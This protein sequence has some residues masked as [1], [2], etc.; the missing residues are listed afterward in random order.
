MY[1][2]R[3]DM[4]F[5][6]P[7]LLLLGIPLLQGSENRGI[8]MTIEFGSGGGSSQQTIY[9]QGDRKRTEY[10]N[11]YGQKKADGSQQPIYGPRIVSITRCDLGQMFELNLDASEYI[12]APYPPKPLTKEEV[13][14][15]GL[16]VPAT[17][18]SDRPTLRIEVTTRDTGERKE[19]FGHTARHVITTR[20]QTPLEGSQSEPQESVTDGWYIDSKD[21]DLNQRL[22]CDR[23]LPEGKHGHTYGYLLAAG[24]NRPVDKP[25]F[26][27]IGEPETGFALQSA[28]TSRG[29]YTPPGGSK[30]QSD[31]RFETQVTQFE[32][33][34]LDAALF[35]I[36]AGFKQVEHIERNPPPSALAR[37]PKDFWQRLKDSVERLFTR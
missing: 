35:E 27:T 25:E 19:I 29:T 2:L 31:S 12:V 26:V 34:P 6:S 5:S 17:Y 23:K 33:G 22:S 21:I 7:W 14:R 11:S 30:K 1:W 20:K 32:E 15:R 16:Q 3:R 28:M 18:A 10:R 24:G 36:P 13:A 8:K 37:E 9:L 4:N